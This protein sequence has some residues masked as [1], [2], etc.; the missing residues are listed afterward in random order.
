M[1]RR[2]FN[3]LAT[4]MNSSARVCLL[5]DLWW[6]FCIF[7][8][9][10]SRWKDIELSRNPYCCPYFSFCEASSSAKLGINLLLWLEQ[11]IMLNSR[12]FILLLLFQ[13]LLMD[14]KLVHGLHGTKVQVR[15]KRNLYKSGLPQY[16][17]DK[18]PDVY[19]KCTS[20]LGGY[21]F[22]VPHQR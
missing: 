5:E 18:Y 10:F 17:E 7:T 9:Y 6:R 3:S 14:P 11:K 13:D 1:H 16:W 20:A 12:V 21:L 8:N 19:A 2:Y 22:V 4:L 15:Y